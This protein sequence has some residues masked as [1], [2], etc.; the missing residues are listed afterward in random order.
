MALDVIEE[1]CYELASQRPEAM[2]EY[3]VFI[4]TNRGTSAD[5]ACHGEI[6]Q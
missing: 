6:F 5:A 4:V 2:N 3:T 1:L